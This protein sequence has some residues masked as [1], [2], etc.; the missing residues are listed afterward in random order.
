M[1]LQALKR[2]RFLGSR[3][4]EQICKD[5]SGKHLQVYGI[6][7]YSQHRTAS[8]F[9]VWKEGARRRYAAILPCPGFLTSP[10]LPESASSAVLWPIPFRSLFE[11]AAA[12][13]ALEKHKLFTVRASKP[14]KHF[15]LAPN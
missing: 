3:R 13:Q 10:C 6:P 12:E 1:Q 15:L 14:T 9:M 11:R 5:L 2:Q 4:A 7:Q 8:C